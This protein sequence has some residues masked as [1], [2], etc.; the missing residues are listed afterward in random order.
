MALHANVVNGGS[1]G[2]GLGGI[3]LDTDV[4]GGSSGAGF[5]GIAIAEDATE[6]DAINSN[7]LIVSVLLNMESPCLR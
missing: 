4:N 2:T 3:N 6:S 5:G 1:G 7:T